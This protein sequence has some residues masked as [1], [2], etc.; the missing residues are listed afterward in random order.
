MD[1]KLRRW[2]MI[3]ALFL[4]GLLLMYAIFTKVSFSLLIASFKNITFGLVIWF[5][6]ASIGIMTALTLRWN[7][8][9]RAKGFKVPFW[10]LFTYR[11]VGFGVSYVT[12]SA[13]IG[14][15]PARAALLTRHKIPFNDALATV[16][17][18]KMIDIT[19]SGI[20]F[21]LGSLLILAT[22]ALP[23]QLKYTVYIVGLIILVLVVYF[24]SRVLNGYNVFTSIFRTLKLHRIE[25][26]KK[27][28]WQLERMERKMVS[29]YGENKMA[30]LSAIGMSALAW[31]FMFME[32]EVL[33]QLVGQNF[34]L[35]QLF[36]VFSVVGAAT[37]IPVP[38]ALGV[39]EAGQGGLFAV[40]GISAAT[41]V[42][43]SLMVRARDLLWTAVGFI[44]AIYYHIGPKFNFKKKRKKKRR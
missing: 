12:P 18:D 32:Y 40:L 37:L 42:A 41:G 29:F 5:L 23:A 13:R 35:Y 38:M 2:L 14:G 20:F 3:G 11:V 7:I 4:F 16:I 9:L 43:L 15:E 24:Y 8:V 28:S 27:V 39:M 26:L 6:I 22:L 25:R 17:V 19:M 30:F 10:K 34:S 33:V 36:F 21:I 44:F 1:K 31:V